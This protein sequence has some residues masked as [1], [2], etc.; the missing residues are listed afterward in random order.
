MSVLVSF[1]MLGWSCVK[2]QLSPGTF[3]LGLACQSLPATAQTLHFDHT[4]FIIFKQATAATIDSLAARSQLALPTV[5]GVTDRYASMGPP[6]PQNDADQPSDLSLVITSKMVTTEQHATQATD[7]AKESVAAPQGIR[8]DKRI[9]VDIVLLSP[10]NH[11]L[12]MSVL[13][14]KTSASLTLTQTLLHR[15]SRSP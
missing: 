5:L 7:S 2:I 8:S 13:Y 3:I 10:I 14:S 9:A 15:G 1:E 4:E 11:H 12:Q 6:M